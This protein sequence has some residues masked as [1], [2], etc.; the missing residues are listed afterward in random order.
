M[1]FFKISDTTKILANKLA[2][3]VTENFFYIEYCIG[4]KQKSE[5]IDP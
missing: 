4:T 2:F 5:R 3:Y 1:D